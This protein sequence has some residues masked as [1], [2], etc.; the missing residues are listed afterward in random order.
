MNRN[1]DSHSTYLQI[2]IN[3]SKI[4]NVSFF[5]ENSLCVPDLLILIINE[6]IL[7]CTEFTKGVALR[8]CIYGSQLLRRS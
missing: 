6:T 7:I 8:K 1:F 4:F 2:D 3:V 5:R